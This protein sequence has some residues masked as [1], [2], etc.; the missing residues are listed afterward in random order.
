M[1][2]SEHRQ[3]RGLY[4]CSCWVG[5]VIPNE[6]FPPVSSRGLP[7]TG[8]V[9]TSTGL[10]AQG[11]HGDSCSVETLSSN[12]SL[13]EVLDRAEQGQIPGQDTTTQ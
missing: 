11:C 3:R 2:S 5:E 6:D 4:T 9:L 1:L 8:E 13:S 7:C 10:L 12:L